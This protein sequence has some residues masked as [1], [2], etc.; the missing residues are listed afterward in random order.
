MKLQTFLLLLLCSTVLL[1]NPIL[2]FTEKV[3]GVKDFAVTL[4]ID[5]QVFQNGTR[6]T[7]NFLV[8]LVVRNHEDFYLEIKNP[9]ELF[10]LKFWYYGRPRRLYFESLD[11]AGMENIELPISNFV[12]LFELLFKML[13]TPLT[14]LKI[15]ENCVTVKPASTFT[16]QAKE[17]VVLKLFFQ[18][19]LIKQIV[20]TPENNQEE[21]VRLTFEDLK[22]GVVVDR[23]FRTR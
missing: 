15:E 21:F 9:V 13:Q 10:G 1:S 23:F 17:P 5:A 4:K 20:I 19:G 3:A 8:D 18:K 6:Y 14:V 2:D 11:Y 7:L 16:A 22:L 12:S